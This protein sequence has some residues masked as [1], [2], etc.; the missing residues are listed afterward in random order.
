VALLNVLIRNAEMR[1]ALVDAV[2]TA[3]EIVADS[4]ALID[5]IRERR[6]RAAKDRESLEYS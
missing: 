2:E 3:K 5:D 1:V 6:A 4:Q